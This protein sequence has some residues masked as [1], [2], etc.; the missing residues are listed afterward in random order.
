MVRPRRV[1]PLSL[2]LGT[3]PLYLFFVWLLSRG[4]D[5]GFYDSVEY[6]LTIVPV[7]LADLVARAGGDG[8]RAIVFWIA[9]VVAIPLVAVMMAYGPLLLVAV[10]ALV[11]LSIVG[12]LA[13][14]SLA[15]IVEVVTLVFYAPGWPSVIVPLVISAYLAYAIIVHRMFRSRF[16]GP[17]EWA[18]GPRVGIDGRRWPIRRGPS[19]ERS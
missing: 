9:A 19:K 4:N 18:E 5:W 15:L 3:L 6:F 12:P 16:G 7:T 10:G 17:R 8:T 2:G 1:W 11:G 14:A 13:L